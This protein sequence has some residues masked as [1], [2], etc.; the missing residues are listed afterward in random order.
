M[1]GD[2]EDSARIWTGSVFGRCRDYAKRDQ[3]ATTNIAVP[4]TLRAASTF[5]QPTRLSGKKP[6]HCKALFVFDEPF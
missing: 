1:A 3:K 6:W 5:R 4:L 2:A